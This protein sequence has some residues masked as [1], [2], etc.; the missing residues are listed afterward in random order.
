MV[1]SI[2]APAVLKCCC[3]MLGAKGVVNGDDASFFPND[4]GLSHLGKS[5]EAVAES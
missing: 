5:S 4:I 3:M 1:V 2:A